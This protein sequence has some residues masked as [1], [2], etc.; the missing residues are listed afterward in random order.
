MIL[1]SPVLDLRY[2]H[3]FRN[4]A[5]GPNGLTVRGMTAGGLPAL[6]ENV[7]GKRGMIRNQ[8]EMVVIEMHGLQ[9]DLKTLRSSMVW[10]ACAFSRLMMETLG[11]TLHWLDQREVK[12]LI[13]S[14]TGSG[15]GGLCCP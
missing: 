10:L 5:V 2:H 12:I 4:A 3:L 9:Y 11:Q 15:L 13:S 7:A 14:D 8:I 1:Q 6:S